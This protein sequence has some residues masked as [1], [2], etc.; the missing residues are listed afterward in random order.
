MTNGE[1]SGDAI[2]KRIM[3]RARSEAEEQK[4]QD[5]SGKDRKANEY[6]E[7]HDRREAAFNEA[8]A[9]SN[10][11]VGYFILNHLISSFEESN[12]TPVM[13]E[14]AYEQLLAHDRERYN[15]TDEEVDEL[16]TRFK[17]LRSK[18]IKE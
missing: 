17:A 10:R 8:A 6:F 14:P 13:D 18:A 16:R 3:E 12:I 4:A 1:E 5:A 11:S 9:K 15:M 2:R 7:E